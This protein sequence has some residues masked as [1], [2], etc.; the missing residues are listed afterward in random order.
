MKRTDR[1][2]REIEV[3]E[4]PPTDLLLVGTAPA[5]IANVPQQYFSRAESGRQALELLKLLRF[6]LLLS[7]LDVPD[8]PAWE[9]FAR[10]RQTQAR[11][12]CALADDRLT[13]KDERRIRQV[14]GAV[15]GSNDPMLHEAVRRLIPAASGCQIQGRTVPERAPP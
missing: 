15:F 14:G 6:R 4:K 13:L 12:Q 1:Y 7:S 10:A 3:D 5:G 11:L 9:L 8:M 2:P